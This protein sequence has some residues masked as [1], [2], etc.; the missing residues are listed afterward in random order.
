MRNIGAIFMTEK[1][2]FI[3]KL[4]AIW[5]SQ[6]RMR[7]QDL[8]YTRVNFFLLSSL[9]FQRIL[10]LLCCALKHVADPRGPSRPVDEWSELF[11]RPQAAMIFE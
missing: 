2:S 1:F 3:F 4:V 5:D 10:N 7:L 11:N 8:S 9:S 6:L